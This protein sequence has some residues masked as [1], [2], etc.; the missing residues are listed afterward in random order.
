MPEVKQGETEDEYIGRCIPYMLKEKEGME[1]DQAA[2]ICYS[3]WNKAKS[4]SIV[5]R[6]NNILTEESETDVENW[7]RDTLSGTT[8]K[9]TADLMYNLCKKKFKHTDK[10]DFEEIWNALIDD[11]YIVKAGGNNYKWEDI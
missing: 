1:K 9:T 11:G 5:K 2:A 4:E 7:I 3:M 8:R 6:I 10:D